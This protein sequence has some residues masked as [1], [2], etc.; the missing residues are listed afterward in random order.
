MKHLPARFQFIALVFSC[1]VLAFISPSTGAS[2]EVS[3]WP[4]WR[5]PQGA[6][7]S[8]EKGL[9]TEW[10]ATKNIQW[11]T[12]LPG[13]GHSSPI[14]WGKKIFLT[15]SFEGPVVPGAKPP[16][17]MIE[18]K[19]FVHPDSVGGTHSYTLKVLCVDAESGK[20]LWEKTA[21]EGTVFDDR[22]KKNT[23]ASP[24]PATDGRHVY[25]YFG[26][27]GIYCYDFK[28]NLIWK[29]SLGGIPNLGMGPGTSPVLH[30]N[31]VFL[32]CDK[33]ASGEGSFI[34]ALDKKSGKEV[35]KVS[36][37]TRMTWATPLL[38][39]TPRRA[40][41]VTSGAES[42]ISYDPATGKELWRCKGV[43]GHAIP[44]PLTGHDMVFVSAGY[45]SKRALAIRLGGT[46]DLTGTSSIAWSY[47]KGT[48]YVPSPILYEDYLYLMTDKGILTCMDARTGDVKYNGRVPVPA[49]F[50]AS[51]VAFDGKI[52]LS[53]EDGDTFVVKAGPVH[54]ILGTNS[55]GEPI[56]ASPAISRGRIFIRGAQ[57]LYCVSMGGGK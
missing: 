28:G 33:E 32:Q 12:P 49:T 29:A 47:D 13:R 35:W 26:S 30:K 17:H 37:T 20:I 8:P 36:R 3:E 2:A 21:Y 54:E 24:T 42:V 7:L 31:L 40:E 53:S 38:I 27:E 45:P 10:S 56:Y 14:V 39:R 48:A 16:K 52:F 23:Y 19:E 57:N 1:S 22:H 46:G 50:T 55:I 6:G 41:L 15:T 43:E 5:G 4:Q 18:D 44:S 51:P 25:A 34:V 9:P 11:K